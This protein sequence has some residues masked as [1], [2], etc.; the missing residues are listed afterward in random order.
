MAIG[1]PIAVLTLGDDEHDRLE[2]RARRPTT[3]QA[4]AQRARIVLA[5]AS[6]RTNTRVARELRLTKQTVRQVAES[7]CRPVAGPPL[8]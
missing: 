2:R 1:R 7:V 3:A 6:G 5:C 8:L 4:L